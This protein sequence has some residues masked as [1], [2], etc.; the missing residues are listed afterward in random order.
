V[1]LGIRGL[2]KHTKRGAGVIIGAVVGGACIPPILASVADRRDSTAFAMIVPVMFFISAETYALAVNFVPSYRNPA[3]KI[4][5]G[6][7]GVDKA[8]LGGGVDNSEEASVE[9]D[10]EKEKV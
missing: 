9:A 10:Y 7:V 8:Y 5:E 6:I 3:D 4:G 1:A 2:G